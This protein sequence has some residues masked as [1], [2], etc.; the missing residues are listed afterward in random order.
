MLESDAVRVR[1][2]RVQI[3]TFNLRKITDPVQQLPCGDCAPYLEQWAHYA[4]TVV[5]SGPL[6]WTVV[7][8]LVDT[9]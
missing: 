7:K 5:S 2:Q 8:G 1:V 9:R 3:S 4:L 6:S